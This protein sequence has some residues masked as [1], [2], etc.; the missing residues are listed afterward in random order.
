[1]N[2]NNELTI[3]GLTILFLRKKWVF[4]IV[5]ILVFAAC[6]TY[7]FL[8]PE[9]Y[10]Y[11]SRLKISEDYIANNNSLYNHYPRD[12]EKLLIFP[13]HRRDRQEDR[14]LQK[15]ANEI[16]SDEMMRDLQ[17]RMDNKTGIRELRDSLNIYRDQDDD[18]VFI[19]VTS[20]DPGTAEELNRKLL[21]AY[22]EKKQAEYE[23]TYEVLLARIKTDVE[24]LESSIE[25]LNTKKNTAEAEYNLENSKPREER[26]IDYLAQ[27]LA[28]AESY[29][30][31]IT[32]KDKDY[33]LL[34]ATLAN[35]EDN[36]DFFVNRILIFQ[37]L[38]L[39]EAREFNL[40][41]SIIYSTM[42]GLIAAFII[43]FIAAV[44][45]YARHAIKH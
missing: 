17:E 2:N 4:I 9:Q 14:Y 19:G 39:V 41:N 29:A 34:A 37:E 7:F 45:S 44:A 40:R 22:I 33:E 31:R 12:L 36:K 16:S 10:T 20:G 27:K 32:S 5:F 35:M 28:A 1:M 23:K 13:T 43:T 26:D 8:Q 3:S 21:D 30:R 25:D 42:I 18:N 38:E 6:L 11:G 24:E 15:I